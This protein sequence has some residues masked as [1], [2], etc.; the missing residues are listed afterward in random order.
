M[1]SLTEHSLQP[2]EPSTATE[3]PKATAKPQDSVPL[4][5][6]RRYCLTICTVRKPGISEDE[7]GEYLSKTHAQISKRLLAK[8]GMIR[9]TTVGIIVCGLLHL[10]QPSLTPPRLL[11]LRGVVF[12]GQELQNLAS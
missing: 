1:S 6:R 10:A 7:F 3:T 4:P 11:V 12:V 2:G 5:K 9:W 8:Y